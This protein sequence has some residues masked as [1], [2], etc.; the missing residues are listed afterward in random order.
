MLFG[1]ANLIL[2]NHQLVYYKPLG[3]GADRNESAAPKSIQGVASELT[4]FALICSVQC[5]KHRSTGRLKTH[6]QESPG[7][8]SQSYSVQC[9]DSAV[10]VLMPHGGRGKGGALMPYRGRWE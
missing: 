4:V 8:Y 5:H 7:S 1:V 2:H 3:G 10:A 6:P 9:Q